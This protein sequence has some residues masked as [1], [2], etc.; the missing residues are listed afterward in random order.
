MIAVQSG[1]HQLGTDRHPRHVCTR[2][3]VDKE[4]RSSDYHTL[5]LTFSF[6]SLSLSVILCVRWKIQ[7]ET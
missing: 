1:V 7:Q 3:C 5:N 4:Q 6:S 2:M